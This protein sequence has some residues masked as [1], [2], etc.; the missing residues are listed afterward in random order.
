MEEALTMLV[1]TLCILEDDDEWVGAGAGAEAG[2]TVECT[3]ADD[4]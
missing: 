4:E 2:A 1:V 3:V